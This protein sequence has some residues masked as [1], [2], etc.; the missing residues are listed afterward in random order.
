MYQGLIGETLMAGLFKE[1]FR[2]LTEKKNITVS[3]TA[4]KAAT[5]VS[6]TQAK[7]DDKLKVNCCTHWYFNLAYVLLRNYTKLIPPVKT[8]LY[9]VIFPYHS[10]EPKLI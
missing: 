5:L 4:L 1:F 9:S 7:T 10:L 8:L 3:L 6:S 2:F